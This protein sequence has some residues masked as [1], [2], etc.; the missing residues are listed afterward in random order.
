MNTLVEVTAVESGD[1]YIAQVRW[2]KTIA[3]DDFIVGCSFACP[4]EPHEIIAIH[5]P[6]G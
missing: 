5:P 2:V 6:I 1:T 4:P 3:A